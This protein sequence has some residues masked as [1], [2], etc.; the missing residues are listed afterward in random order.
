VNFIQ[1]EKKTSNF[2]IFIDDNETTS[3]CL[4][5]NYGNVWAARRTNI[6]TSTVGNDVLVLRSS[7]GAWLDLDD[8]RM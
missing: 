3:L 5:I 2:D 6:G 8:L 1:L 4:T 7:I